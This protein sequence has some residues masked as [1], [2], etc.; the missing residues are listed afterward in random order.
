MAESNWALLTVRACIAT[1]CGAEWCGPHAI[2]R[3]TMTANCVDLMGTSK[4]ER[5]VALS[6]SR[7]LLLL[8][9][10]AQT[11]PSGHADVSL[12][13]QR[14]DSEESEPRQVVPSR[15]TYPRPIDQTIGKPTNGMWPSIW[16][17]QRYVNEGGRCTSNGITMSDIT[18]HTHGP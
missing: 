7:S 9:G 15:S 2:G 13:E 4:I 3:S 10:S 12:L 14:R 5:L 18:T 16:M 1:C 17:N 6:V 8:P 11:V